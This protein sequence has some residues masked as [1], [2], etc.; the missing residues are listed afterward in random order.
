V[1]RPTPEPF[2]TKLEAAEL[3]KMAETIREQ[4]QLAVEVFP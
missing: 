2:A 1:A 3:E 4:T